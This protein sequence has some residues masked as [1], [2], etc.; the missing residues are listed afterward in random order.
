M[1]AVLTVM[2]I[3]G[4]A[5]GHV[6]SRAYEKSP[7]VDKII[8]APGNSFI[9]YKRA[10][11]VLVD[12][13]CSLKDPYS[14]LEIAHK[15][16][17]DIIDVAQDDALACGAV[18]LLQKHGFETFGPSQKAARIE[19]DKRHSREFMQ[20]HGIPAPASAILTQKP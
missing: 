7:D 14:I 13:N 3:D 12:K 10:K 8:V 9:T 6:L 1:D 16:H 2:V 18:N 11:D 15:Y 20:R 19:W 5:R 17:P 4:G